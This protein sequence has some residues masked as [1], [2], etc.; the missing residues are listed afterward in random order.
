MNRKKHAT[1]LTL[2]LMLGVL[3]TAQAQRGQAIYTCKAA[4]G[5]LT[6]QNAPCPQGSQVQAA[7]PYVDPGY[8]PALAAKVE[9][10]RRALARRKQQAAY[11]P[12]SVAPARSDTPDKVRR[13]RQAK[14]YRQ[15]TLD[16]VGLERT[17]E[18]LRR[19]DDQV[20][21]AC[22]YAPGA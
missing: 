13:C 19:L 22:K 7:K 6:Y 20:Y 8:D 15:Q 5:K 9:A 21:E 11:S 10:D 17:Y 18:L 14:A 1:P 12:Q 2:L 3:T 4:D 16:L